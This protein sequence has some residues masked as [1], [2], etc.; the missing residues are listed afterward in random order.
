MHNPKSKILGCDSKYSWF[1]W[2]EVFWLVKLYFYLFAGSSSILVM[3]T[4]VGALIKTDNPTE[5]LE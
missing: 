5:M 2:S 1:L 3:D 4:L